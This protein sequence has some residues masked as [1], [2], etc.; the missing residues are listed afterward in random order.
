MAFSKADVS[1]CVAVQGQYRQ[2]KIQIHLHFR[3]QEIQK[4]V[5]HFLRLA[6]CG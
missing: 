4:I 2:L 6:K 3:R 5:V 1:D